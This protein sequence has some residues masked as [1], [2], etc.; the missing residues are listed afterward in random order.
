MPAAVVGLSGSIDEYN[1]DGFIRRFNRAKA[2]GAKTIIVDID[3]WGG[4]VISGLE[5]SEFLKGQ[6]DVYTIAYVNDRAVSAGAMIA[7]AC[8][9]IVMT[10]SAILGDCADPVQRGSHARS[11]AP[12]RAG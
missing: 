2:D 1:R 9:E 4:L 12:R 5:I 7:M 8:N 10:D 3:T 11:P 6:N